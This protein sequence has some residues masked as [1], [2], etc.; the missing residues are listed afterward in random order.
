MVGRCSQELPKSLRQSLWRRIWGASLLGEVPEGGLDFDMTL[1]H[2][3]GVL[4]NVL[5]SE[6]ADYIPRVGAD[7]HPGLPKQLRPDFEKIAKGESSSAK[8]ARVRMAPLLNVLYRIDPEWTERALFNRMDLDE[9]TTFDPHLWEGY[10]WHTRWSDDLLVAFK[11][12][13]FKVLRNLDRIPERV[14]HHGPQLFL[15][16]AVPP[17]RGVS[18]AEAKGG[19]HPS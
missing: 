1:N 13:L 15:Y 6:M 4:G 17:D 12:L 18:T 16:M 8:L 5:Y 7:E 10:L 14:R 19:R 3:G 2:A 11:D 9:D